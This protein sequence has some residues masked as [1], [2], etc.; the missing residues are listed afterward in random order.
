V[1]TN[2]DVV[3]MDVMLTSKT[4]ELEDADEDS[5]AATLASLRCLKVL[6]KL[7]DY[8][9]SD[10]FWAPVSNKEAPGYS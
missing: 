7:Y 9:D 8:R 5:Q 3:D 2:R 1:T 10:I 6:K 4:Q